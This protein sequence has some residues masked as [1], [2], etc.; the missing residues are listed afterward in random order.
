MLIVEDNQINRTVIQALL[1]TLGLQSAIAQ[2]GREGIEMAA[3]HDYDAIFMDCLMPAVDGF[4]ATREIR[5]TE[6]GRRV[7]IIAMTALS[8]PGDR[9][10]CLTAGMDDYLSK[11]IRRPALEAAV[12]RWLPIAAQPQVSPAENPSGSGD[13]GL[14]AI[15]SPPEPDEDVLDQAIVGQ[16]R[17]ALPAE[18]RL[19]LIDTFEGQHRKCLTEI[20]AAVGRDDRDEV[21]RTAHLLKGS[22]ASLGA[23]R[24]R[25]Q[26]ERLEHIGRAGDQ[27]VSETQLEQVRV[28][29]A[30]AGAAL[31]QQLA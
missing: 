15:A 6:H 23:M 29:A 19:E 8:M 2:D 1:A 18:T 10:R 14:G 26:C 24:L 17:D 20:A 11:P 5:R 7:P 13:A 4:Q 25:S 22:S 27:R 31:R 28:A 30:E 3:V 9:E 12:E 16:L 21:R